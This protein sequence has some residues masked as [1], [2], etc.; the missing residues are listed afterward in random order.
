MKKAAKKSTTVKAKVTKKQ[1]VSGV[2]RTTTVFVG[3]YGTMTQAKADAAQY[4]L[5]NAIIYRSAL[6]PNPV[7]FQVGAAVIEAVAQ[8]AKPSISPLYPF[9][10]KLTVRIIGSEKAVGSWSRAFLVKA[11]YL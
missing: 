2:S 1:A 9:T 8:A 7:G 10:I 4:M 5:P 11:S 6:F 3:N